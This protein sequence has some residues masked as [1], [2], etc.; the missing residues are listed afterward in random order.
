[1]IHV[2]SIRIQG[3]LLLYVKESN[4]KELLAAMIMKS[5]KKSFLLGAVFN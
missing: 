1:M 4:S 3:Q 5:K 2:S